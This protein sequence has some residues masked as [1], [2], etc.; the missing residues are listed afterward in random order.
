VLE[1]SFYCTAQL[2][3]LH[4]LK[5]VFSFPIPTPVSSHQLKHHITFFSKHQNIKQQYV[6]ATEILN[7]VINLKSTTSE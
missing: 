6:I 7:A 1:A 5:P 3:V 4:K 2:N